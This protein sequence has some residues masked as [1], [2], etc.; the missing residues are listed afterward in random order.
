[1]P[2]SAIATGRLVGR[3]EKYSVASTGR[4]A[5]MVIRT[6]LVVTAGNATG[7]GTVPF[8]TGVVPTGGTSTVRTCP[9]PASIVIRVGT[10]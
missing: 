2:S 6:W 8:S 7:A 9:P 1:M 5:S 10:E 4:I 3:F